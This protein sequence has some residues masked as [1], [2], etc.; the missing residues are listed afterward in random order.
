MFTDSW[1]VYF[2][3]SG[4]VMWVLS[5]LSAKVTNINARFA[6]IVACTAIAFSWFVYGVGF[7]GVEP[8][9]YVIFG[10]ISVGLFISY[11]NCKKEEVC[12]AQ[13]SAKSA[14]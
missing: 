12:E 6:I 9:I 14:K 3:C 1:I 13:D 10:A 5:L 8:I 4:I 7:A 2:L 11:H